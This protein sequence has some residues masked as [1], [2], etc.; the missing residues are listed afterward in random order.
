MEYFFNCEKYSD[1]QIMKKLDSRES[2]DV[3]LNQLTN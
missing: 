1:A 2:K 3:T